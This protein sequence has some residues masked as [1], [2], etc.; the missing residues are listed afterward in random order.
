MG[1]RQP[2]LSFLEKECLSP[3]TTPGIVGTQEHYDSGKGSKAALDRR[4]VAIL[5]FDNAW[6]YEPGTIPPCQLERNY[7]VKH[8]LESRSRCFKYRWRKRCSKAA[9]TDPSVTGFGA[10]SGSLRQC[11]FSEL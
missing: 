11:D 10:F 4:I 5:R 2:F 3:A 9:V 1:D 7:G 6:N 8:P